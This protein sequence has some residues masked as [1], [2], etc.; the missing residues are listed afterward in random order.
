LFRPSMKTWDFFAHLSCEEGGLAQGNFLLS[1]Y[2]SQDHVVI[3][4]SI[5]EREYN[6]NLIVSSL[7]LM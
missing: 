2:S 3:L 1:K 5:H 4:K 7:L 6:K